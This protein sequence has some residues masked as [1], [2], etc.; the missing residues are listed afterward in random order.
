MYTCFIV[1][2]KH[3]FLTT[4]LSCHKTADL[5][6]STVTLPDSATSNQ[7]NAVLALVA[8]ITSKMFCFCFFVFLEAKLCL[9]LLLLFGPATSNQ[10][11]RPTLWRSPNMPKISAINSNLCC[12]FPSENDL[13][14]L[15][16]LIFCLFMYIL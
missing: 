14:V 15:N 16:A 7:P 10:S 6:S 8:D 2:Q 5:G 3:M 4:V 1:K 9:I 13:I 11:V 12:A